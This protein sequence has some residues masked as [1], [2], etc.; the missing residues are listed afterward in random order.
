ML[1]IKVRVLD[2]SCQ[3]DDEQLENK[4][5]KAAKERFCGQE[6]TAKEDELKEVK[7]NVSSTLLVVEPSLQEDHSTQV[8][9]Q[10]VAS[11]P[12]E[13]PSVQ[14]DVFRK[15]M[16]K[17]KQ[18]LI[19]PIE[20]VTFTVEPMLEIYLRNFVWSSKN[21]KLL[22]IVMDFEVFN[23]N[24]QKY[25]SSFKPERLKAVVDIWTN[26]VNADFIALG[27]V[28]F[29]FN[30]NRQLIVIDIQRMKGGHCAE[31]IQ[32]A[33][34][35]IINKYCVVCDE[36]SSLVRLF[37]QLLDQRIIFG[38]DD[39][40]QEPSVDLITFSNIMDKFKNKHS[41]SIADP[42]T[43]DTDSIEPGVIENNLEGVSALPD[44]ASIT[45]EIND[46]VTHLE[47][48]KFNNNIQL[49]ARPTEKI[50]KQIQYNDEYDLTGGSP[51]TELN[52]KIGSNKIPRFQCACHKLNFAIKHA[53]DNHA[54]LSNLLKDFSVSNANFRR[55]IRISRERKREKKC[56][57]R[58]QNL[59]RWS[60]AYLMMESVKRAAYLMNTSIVRKWVKKAF[61]KNMLNDDSQIEDNIPL[62]AQSTNSNYFYYGFDDDQE[63]NNTN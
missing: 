56:R 37:G 58:L 42:S 8:K 60:S 19:E 43:T 27:A 61:A 25:E 7:E 5:F 47:T 53:I 41:N 54:E 45:K 1:L 21:S 18:N 50:L 10:L 57:L 9:S 49:S 26:R 36:G 59:T 12:E 17:T 11:S 48:L 33:I 24:F 40:V 55:S 28:L 46:I 34:E 14:K 38:D 23:N 4:N 44:V 51:I 39:V 15:I 35:D 32:I 2:A 20:S 13:V 16:S 63:T 3:V 6:Y 52:L 22:C 62:S 30:F 31:N 29:D